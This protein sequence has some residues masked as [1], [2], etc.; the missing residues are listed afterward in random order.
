M[1]IYGGK[2]ADENFGLKHSQA[3]LLSMVR[4]IFIR[5]LGARCSFLF[6][7]IV[8]AIPMD[9]SFS[10]RAPTVNFSMGNM[11]SLVSDGCLERIPSFFLS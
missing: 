9:V 11:L 8:D 4:M 1:S 7:R 2:F 3:G 5:R 10:S 6:R